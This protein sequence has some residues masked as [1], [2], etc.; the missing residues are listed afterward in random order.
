MN[1]TADETAIE[2]AAAALRAG[3]VVAHATEGVWGFACDPFDEVAVLKILAIKDRPVE[4]GLLV[5]GDVGE[6]DQELAAHSVELREQASASWP[7]P[8]TWVLP[9]LRFPNWVTGDQSGIACRVP[10]HRQARML[11]RA[12]G[13][14]LVST[15]ANRAGEPSLVDETAVR[16]QFTEEVAHILPGQVCSPGKASTIYSLLGEPIRT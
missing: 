4:K 11:C 7:G 10:G 12:F 3:G 9:N 8:S 13:G 6:F 16:A 14:P 15:S 5:I 1:A 2:T